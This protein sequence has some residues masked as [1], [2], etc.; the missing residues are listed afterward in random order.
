MANLEC[1]TFLGRNDIRIPLQT[2]LSPI[3]QP[4]FVGFRGEALVSFKG[5]FFQ[6][7]WFQRLTLVL[8]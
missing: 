3:G 7:I 2:G 8:I 6:W 5:R 4:H 1:I